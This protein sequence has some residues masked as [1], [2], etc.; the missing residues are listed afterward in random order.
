MSTPATR[1]SP[2]W[3]G[4]GALTA[5]LLLADL[6]MI[7]I[8][9]PVELRMGIV[10][11]IFYFHVPSAYAM[12]VGFA[13]CGIASAGYLVRRTE[14]WDAVAVAGAEIGLLFCLIVLITG[15]LWARKAWGVWWTW[16]P[17]LT[18]TMLA[19]MIFA[20]YVVLRSF[21]D[22][23]EAERRFASALAIVGLFVL[24]I[25]HYSVQRWRGTHPTV[26]TSQGGGLAP[27][28]LQTLLFSI[29]AFTALVA[30]LIWTRTR[31]E[32]TRQE[33]ARLEVEAAEVGLLEDT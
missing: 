4:L 20:A 7:F 12:Y 26:I 10:Q 17:R 11:K 5:A 21:G 29:G 18:T 28:M 9:A 23:G 1:P 6:Y 8:Y 3:L 15:P 2:I 16:D 32:R 19:G 25:I 13:I 27:E 14:R 22:A 30:W 33:L 31:H 24:P